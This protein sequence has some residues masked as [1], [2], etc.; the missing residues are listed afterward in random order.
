MYHPTV[1]CSR[2]PKSHPCVRYYIL[3]QWIQHELEL[4]S[5]KRWFLTAISEW[6][7]TTL[8]H[9]WLSAWAG[10]P[11]TCVEK[12]RS[13]VSSTSLSFE[14]QEATL[15][16]NLRAAR[17]DSWPHIINCLILAASSTAASFYH[18]LGIQLEEERSSSI[19]AYVRVAGYLNRHQRHFRGIRD[20][21]Y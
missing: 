1:G 4:W 17:S 6:Q 16:C 15:D 21:I 2:L 20:H 13:S 9:N 10:I 14:Q 3:T 18:N 8:D 11:S 5:S 19:I 7:E 12:Y